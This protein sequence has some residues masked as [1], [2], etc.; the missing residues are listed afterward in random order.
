METI[1]LDALSFSDYGSFIPETQFVREM[2]QAYL[3]ED[4]VGTPG[5]A[6]KTAFTVQEGG[7]YRVFVRT[8]NWLPD[9]T[10]DSL[11][12]SVD[13]VSSQ[14]K[15]GTAHIHGWHFAYGG[16][17][18]LSPGRHLLSLTS[19]AG[20]FARFAAVVIT[21][22]MDYLPSPEKARWQK[23]R[24]QYFYYPET[25]TALFNKDIF[26]P[27][28]HE[29]TDLIVVGAG[30]AGITA[31]IAAARLG[32][33]TILVS[34]RPVL[35]GNGSE[36][37]SVA[38]EGAAHRGV[39][40][41]GI[42]LEIKLY[43]HHHR[44]SWSEAFRH[45]VDQEESLCVL[46]NLMIDRA[47]T[48]V[49]PP[50][51]AYSAKITTIHGVDTIT[52]REHTWSADQY[53]D[54]T[55]DGWLGYEAGALYRV[56]REAVFQHNEPFAL[57]EGDGITMSGCANRTVREYAKTI[58]SYDAEETDAPVPFTAPRWAFKMPEGDELSRDVAV[59]TH[60][61]WWLENR[62][63]YDDLF[64]S[65]ITRDALIRMSLGYF[66][67]L[68]NSW[69]DREKAASLRLKSI[70]TYN[71]KRET[72]RLIGDYI[73]TQNDFEP[74][75]KIDRSDLTD[76][77]IEKEVLSTL[78][79]PD[80]VAYTGWAIDVHHKDG[81]FSGKESAFFLNQRCKVTPIPFRTLYSKNIRNLMMAGRNT[82]VTHLALG[83]T[84][85]MLTGALMGQAVGTAAY[86]NKKY[87][88]APRETGQQ[89]MDELQSLLLKGGVYL[90]RVTGHDDTDLI[91]DASLVISKAPLTM[92]YRFKENKKVREISLTFALPYTQF[93]YGKRKDLP[94]MPNIAENFTL[95]LVLPDDARLQVA[96]VSGNYQYRASFAV[97]ASAGG[98][99]ITFIGLKDEDA[100]VLPKV[101]CLSAP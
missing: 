47:E 39:H 27:L 71:A 73:M 55:G 3:L 52:L 1:W 16:D 66:D 45:F 32:L 21:N 77:I 58:C 18:L 2:G 15:V 101:S 98:V 20:W 53:I 42:I 59:M 29:K 79:F 48:Q 11:C 23:D 88:A 8:K 95:A 12:V 61:E 97:D 7:Y 41:R 62:G 80:T 17:F 83:S 67:W 57:K 93:S 10:P 37:V 92:T 6:A 51:T 14:N 76:E 28:V 70:G 82:S 65:E 54:A 5:N 89:H 72:R 49:L 40:E 33:K 75:E 43:R 4:A 50:E 94:P 19:S 91:P 85:V 34:D 74:C 24:E 31:A 64:E 56:G 35:G 60:G 78:T 44:C 81:I 13:T 96:S 90:P 86:L 100:F 9:E 30:A 84:R 68:K 87:N 63:D 26:T 46:D 69:K 22:D 99:E 25:N 38:L 36:E